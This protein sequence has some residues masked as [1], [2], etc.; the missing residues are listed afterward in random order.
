MLSEG[1]T[2]LDTVATVVAILEDDPIFNAGRG[3]VVTKE[4]SCQVVKRAV[5]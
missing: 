3:A 4:D 2:A 1:S 5:T